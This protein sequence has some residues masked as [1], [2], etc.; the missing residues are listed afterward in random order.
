MKP[1]LFKKLFVS[2]FYETVIMCIR[3][4]KDFKILKVSLTNQEPLG[5]YPPFPL[6]QRMPFATSSFTAS[7]LV[8][9]L[10][11]ASPFMVFLAG[12]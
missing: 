11:A 7:P 1:G 5:V 9:L 2:I 3:S 4:R 6:N 10:F 8:A 12:H